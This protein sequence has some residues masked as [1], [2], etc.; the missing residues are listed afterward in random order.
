MSQVTSRADSRLGDSPDGL[1]DS[2]AVAPAD[3]FEK[4]F[5]FF[6][7]MKT[8]LALIL[9]LGILTL[10]GT[11]I[12]QAPAELAEDPGLYADW[13]DSTRE[14]FGGWTPIIDRL[15]LFAVFSSLVFKLIAMLLVTSIIACSV[16][17]A[18]RLWKH[19]THARTR[20]SDSYFA[21]APL[22]ASAQVDVPPDDGLARVRKVLKR[23]HYRVLDGPSGANTRN[24]YAERF[25]W[26]PF[27]TIIAHLSFVLILIGVFLTATTGFKEEQLAVPVGSTIDV[28]HDTGLS[29]LARSFSDSYYPDGS[30]ADYASQLVLYEDGVAVQEQTVRVNEPMRYSGVSFYQSFFGLAAAMSVRD[31]SGR[32]LFNEGV[33]LAWGT[34]DGVHNVGEFALPDQGLRVFVVVPASGEVDPNIR[35]GQVQLEIYRDDGESPLALKVL[36]Q[37]KPAVIDGI[38]Y[39]F[40]RPRQFTGLIVTQDPGAVFVWIGSFFLVVGIFMVFF[41]PHRRIWL[42]VG[43]SRTG[44]TVEMAASQRRDLA[45]QAQFKS[46]A[47]DIEAMASAPD[48]QRK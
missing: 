4:L 38:E 39:T 46:L 15:G 41:F 28:G 31:S 13:L 29:V 7:S 9:G 32:V 20:K 27:G 37:G 45:F 19:A 2:I 18:P 43:E 26:G 17:R 44:S 25:R 6:I 1:A 3:V 24:L 40:E 48:P 5:R 34:D 14:I 36:S 10:A 12:R 16:N 35:P 30:P 33:P 11:L 8:G 47:R 22:R 21:H 42:R 23:R